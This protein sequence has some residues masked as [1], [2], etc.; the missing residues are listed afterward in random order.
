[1]KKVQTKKQLGGNGVYEKETK[2]GVEDSSYSINF[3]VEMN[4]SDIKIP[5][6]CIIFSHKFRQILN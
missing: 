5:E 3:P 1:M 2:T 4:S 6:I